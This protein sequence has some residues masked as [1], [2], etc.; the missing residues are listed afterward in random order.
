MTS[1]RKQVL[2]QKDAVCDEVLKKYPKAKIAKRISDL[3]DNRAKG[4]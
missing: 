2:D 1:V 4:L 3:I